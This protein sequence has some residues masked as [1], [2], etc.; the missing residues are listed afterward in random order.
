M[1]EYDTIGTQ[2]DVIKTASYNRVEQSNFRNSVEPFLQNHGTTILDFACGTGFYS[3][4]LLKWGSPSM[5]LTGLDISSA[6]V[7]GASARLAKT[8]YT[9]RAHFLHADGAAPKFYGPPGS[10]GFDVATG[11]WFLNYAKD[12]QELTAMFNC[13]STNLSPKG[14]FVG[15]CMP[16][17]D[18]VAGQARAFNSEPLLARG[19]VRYEYGDELKNRDGFPCHVFAIPPPGSPPSVKGVDFWTYHLKKSVY[20]KAARNGGMNGK[21]EWR[22]CDFPEDYQEELGLSDEEWRI[23]QTYPQNHILVLWKEEDVK[24]AAV[25]D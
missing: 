12:K 14:V 24:Y 20:E 23:V 6:M 9:S 3:E 21:L 17:T 16:P 7:D 19:G 22:S 4:L 18:D 11:A 13:I 2:Y 8:P 25:E 1:P 5:T 15:I 10:E